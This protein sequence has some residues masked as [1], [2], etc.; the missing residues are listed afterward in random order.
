MLPT[1]LHQ[2]YN[3][4]PWV[5]WCCLIARDSILIL[6]DYCWS[7]KWVASSLRLP[8]VSCVT[9]QWCLYHCSY[10]NMRHLYAKLADY[11]CIA[12]WVA[13]AT[14]KITSAEHRTTLLATMCNQHSDD[15]RVSQE[16]IQIINHV[17]NGCDLMNIKAQEQ[18]YQPACA[19]EVVMLTAS[20]SHMHQIQEVIGLW[21][22][23]WW[24][25]NSFERYGM[26]S[27]TRH[28]MKGYPRTWMKTVGMSLLCTLSLVHQ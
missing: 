3:H 2:K 25:G 24:V 11:D 22:S 5:R 19:W 10:S 27:F 28:I 14:T 12:I 9:G 8:S 17:L 20:N 18:H 4:F 7:M 16:Y 6:S 23:Y 13:L 26:N 15:L 21:K 1:L